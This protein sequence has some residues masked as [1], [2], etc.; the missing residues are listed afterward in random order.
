MRRLHA[1]WPPCYLAHRV[2]PRAP[3][4]P[5]S[6]QA[7]LGPLRDS[8]SC[9]NLARTP[10]AARQS[11]SAFLVLSLRAPSSRRRPTKPR[12]VGEAGSWCLSGKP[13]P[14]CVA[15][16]FMPNIEPVARHRH[17]EHACRR[18]ARTPTGCIGHRPS[19]AKMRACSQAGS[20]GVVHVFTFLVR[21]QTRDASCSHYNL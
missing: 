12:T 5:R 21:G 16:E 2:I 9:S 3:G 7:A 15:P 19:R 6:A 18:V 4:A 10:P 17:A 1:A 14:R 20:R 13:H 11:F 8:G